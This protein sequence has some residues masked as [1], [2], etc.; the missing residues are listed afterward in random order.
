MA[1]R[2]PEDE[3]DDD[4]DWDA[5]EN[6]E[7]TVECPYCGGEVHED[8]QRCP[9]CEKYISEEDAPPARKP[10][11]IVVGAIACLYVVYRWIAG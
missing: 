4:E 8:C 5:E 1:R 11:W 7:P 10:W 2:D 3:W 6:D 9:H